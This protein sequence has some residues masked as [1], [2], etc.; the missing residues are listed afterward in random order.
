MGR[1]FVG[2]EGIFINDTNGGA[3]V[4]Q[5]HTERRWGCK[6]SPLLSF[7][8]K[9]DKKRGEKNGNNEKKNGNS[10]KKNGN[11]EKSST[12]TPHKQ[13]FMSEIS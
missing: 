8:G 13:L 1:F 6:G 4:R 9:D 11:S 7:L 3:A 5:Q 2:C 12:F 10:E